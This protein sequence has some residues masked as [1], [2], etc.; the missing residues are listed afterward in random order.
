MSA[1]VSDFSQENYADTRSYLVPGV[2]LPTRRDLLNDYLQHE[3][4]LA[5][6]GPDSG[7][8]ARAYLQ[9]AYSPLANAAWGWDSAFGWTMVALDQMQDFV[10]AQTYALRYDGSSRGDRGPLGPRLGAAQRVRPGIGGVRHPDRPLLDRLAAAVRDS[11]LPVVAGDPGAGACGLPAQ[12][13]WCARELA[14]ATV[15]DRWAPF[16]VW[17]QPALAFVTPPQTITAGG[18]TAPITVQLR[19][20]GLPTATRTR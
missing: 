14:G 10:S 6:T 4:R 13:A 5:G 19:V 8:A 2:P 3:L 17:A 9:A 7:A 20:G 1:Y 18:V 16:N 15:S 11:A 12:N